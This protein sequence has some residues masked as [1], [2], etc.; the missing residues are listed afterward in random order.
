MLAHMRIPLW[1]A[2]LLGALAFAA[3]PGGSL[4]TPREAHA[5]T[6]IAYTLEELVDASPW[7]VVATTVEQKSAWEVIAGGKR[8]VTY[9]KLRIERAIYGAA[10]PRETFPRETVPGATEDASPEIWVRTLGGAVGKVG[11]AVAGEASFSVGKRSLSFLLETKDGKFVVSGAAQGHY[12]IVVP[13][14]ADDRD[15][16]PV[17]RH[18]PSMGRIVR[19]QGPNITVQE[20]LIGKALDDAIAVIAATKAARDALQSD[21]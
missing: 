17:V 4:V 18:S 14:T 8:I 2:C 6:A 3:V 10:L 16:K 20:V 15:A 1:T 13:Q 5:A 21:Q 9:S 7:A 12:P 19:R 11:Q